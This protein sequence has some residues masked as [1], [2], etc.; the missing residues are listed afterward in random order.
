[1]FPKKEKKLFNKIVTQLNKNSIKYSKDND[2]TKSI[3]KKVE[4][5]KS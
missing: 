5:S 1:M 4:V 2:Q 3:N